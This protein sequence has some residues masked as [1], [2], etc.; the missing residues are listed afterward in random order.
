M[1]A[2]SIIVLG[3]PSSGK[4]TYIAAMRHVLLSDET[5]TLLAMDKMSADEKHLNIL[6]SHWLGLSP[7][8]RTREKSE[9]WVT[10]HVVNRLS[11]VGAQV[12]IP[13][14]RGEIF[15]RPAAFGTCQRQIA[16]ALAEADGILLFTN[17]EKADDDLMISD[18]GDAD[19]VDAGIDQSSD[20]SVGVSEQPDGATAV[21]S[22]G[23]ARFRP[24]RMPE[25]AKLVEL[26]QFANRRPRVRRRRRL[27]VIVSADVLLEVLRIG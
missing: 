13:D 26:L 18:Y 4:T 1:N 21:E 14:L 11:K 22:R 10:L 17:A 3:M 6:Q 20:A 23:R 8:Q 5:P 2:R 27:S 19:D 16:E 24:D 25:E 15:E 9:S 7:F 12:E